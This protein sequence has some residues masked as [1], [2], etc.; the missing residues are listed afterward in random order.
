MAI[1]DVQHVVK[2]FGAVRAVDGV[3]FRVGHGVDGGA[4]A[5]AA[6]LDLLYLIAAIWFFSHML[7][8]TRRSGGL[9]RFA[10]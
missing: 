9:A 7:V 2:R 8:A 4:L 1:L 10:E 3:S 5:A 6:A